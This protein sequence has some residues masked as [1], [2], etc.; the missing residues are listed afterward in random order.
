MIA[1]SQM[2][3]TSPLSEGCLFIGCVRL[4]QRYELKAG[5]MTYLV[6]TFLHVRKRA[7]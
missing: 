2:F 4:P 5:A 1:P 6:R 7:L 3:E